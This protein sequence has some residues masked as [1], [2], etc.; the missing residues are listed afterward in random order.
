M[1]PSELAAALQAAAD[2]QFLLDGARGAHLG[3]AAA[4]D[5]PALGA[6]PGLARTAAG[7]S[8][9]LLSQAA[10]AAEAGD[11][12]DRAELYALA[13]CALGC[14][15]VVVA[16]AG[17]PLAPWASG[18]LV[19]AAAAAAAVIRYA[20]ERESESESDLE[21][22]LSLCAELADGVSRM[23][24]ALLTVGRAAG[25]AES[26]G[27][28]A[29]AC[30]AAF[31]RVLGQLRLEALSRRAVEPLAGLRVGLRRGGALDMTAKSLG[32]EW[33]PPARDPRACVSPASPPCSPRCLSS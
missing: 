12:S 5:A 3:A 19:R 8:V 13:R 31:A 29:A 24:C 16:D 18:A 4:A 17:A 20:G 14:A 28:F 26:L 1:P 33:W 10:A 2:C 9:L 23:A 15:C 22:L 7:L 21:A 32:V 6:A 25:V 30:G 27:A 11:V